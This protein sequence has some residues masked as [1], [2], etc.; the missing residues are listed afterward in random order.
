MHKIDCKEILIMK[1]IW[2]II[3]LLLPALLFS[4]TDLLKAVRDGDIEFIQNYEGDINEAL[5]ENGNTAVIIAAYKGNAE[6]VKVLIAAKADIE[7][8]GANGGTALNIAAGNGYIEVV[9]VLIAA[10]A[11]IE[12]VDGVGWTALISAAGNGYAEVVKI[13][14][15][16]KA[17][18]EAVDGDGWT[19]EYRSYSYNTWIDGG[20]NLASSNF[21][22]LLST[23][24]NI[25]V[26]GGTN[27]AITNGVATGSWPQGA[28]PADTVLPWLDNSSDDWHSF[29][30]GPETNCFLKIGNYIVISSTNLR[31]LCGQQFIKQ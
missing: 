26:L 4:T 18:F 20:T 10:K 30:M 27:I 23:T 17:D 13:L 21:M 14:I 29:E 6:V 15:A 16:A 8:V 5:I 28:P 3:M 25:T 12:T 9:K 2:A 7:A 1:N 19:G 24:S 11:D 22:L 31:A